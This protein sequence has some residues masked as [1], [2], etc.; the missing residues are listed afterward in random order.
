MYDI[1]LKKQSG[2]KVIEK[3][4]IRR[5]KRLLSRFDDDEENSSGGK[6]GGGHG[7]TKI[8]FG[9]CQR[10]GIEINPKWT[11]KDAWDALAG[12]GYSASD[13]YKEL[14]ETGKVAPKE[15]KPKTLTKKDAENE[16]KKLVGDGSYS[17]EKSKKISEYISSLPIGT[18]VVFPDSWTSDDGTKNTAVYEGEGKWRW[19]YGR[20]KSDSSSLSSDEMAQYFLGEDEE[21]RVKLASFPKEKKE[22]KRNTFLS[23]NGTVVGRHVCDFH[24][25]HVSSEER[26]TF[27]NTI[28]ELVQ[29]GDSGRAE[30]GDKIIEEI[31]RRQKLR[32]KDVENAPFNNKPQVDDIYDVLRDVRQFGMPKDFKYKVDSALGKEKTDAIIKEAFDMFP[33][34]WLKNCGTWPEIHI[35]DGEGRAYCA[36]HHCIYVYTKEKIPTLEGKYKEHELSESG[37]VSVLTHELGHYVEGNNADVDTAAQLSFYDRTRY[38]EPEDLE[39]GFKTMPDSFFH[40]YMG[41]IYPWHSTEI[42]SVLMQYLYCFDPFDKMTGKGSKVKDKESLRFI[43]GNLAGL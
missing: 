29:I 26:E 12:K 34:D 42:T 24:N 9:L 1:A 23:G 21:E 39:P 37:L 36:N 6:R 35:I 43:L 30:A 7:N 38:S 22:K 20:K 4:R 16:I 10:E 27:K 19:R 41:K 18:K 25:D 8:P 31:K 11:P 3:Y 17:D 13:V 2:A 5:S 14:R 40:T 28:K 33:T 15:S 32:R